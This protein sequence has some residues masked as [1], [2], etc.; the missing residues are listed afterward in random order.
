MAGVI[1]VSLQGT[2]PGGEVFSV[3]PVW[4][5][6]D[7]G[8]SISYAECTAIVAAIN[9]LT[10]PA[11]ITNMITSGC[12][13]TGCRV[14]ARSL[15]GVLEALA[16]GNRAAP[17]AGTGPSDKTFSTA[18]VLSLKTAL[19]GGRGRGRL[20]WPATGVGL[21]PTTLR[22]APANVSTFLS[23]IK[24]YL[25]AI[26]GAIDASVDGGMG[27]VVWSRTNS[28]VSLVNTVQ[29]GDVLDTQRRRRD[30]VTEGYSSLAWP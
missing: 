20:Y 30:A 27:L 3:N 22:V 13:W 10:I 19:P 26:E 18:M 5:L 12:A 24:G 7:F 6:N 21:S 1:K 25:A 4:G 16:E 8:E 15:A 28:A 17:V 23:A 14:E 29:M 2:M 9:A 11:A